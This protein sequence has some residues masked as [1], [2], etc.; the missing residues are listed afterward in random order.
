MVLTHLSKRIVFEAVLAMASVFVLWSAAS[1]DESASGRQR[2]RTIQPAQRLW[3]GNDP[4]CPQQPRPRLGVQ[5]KFIHLHDDGPVFETF[6]HGGGGGQHHGQEH[7]LRFHPQPNHH[8]YRHGVLIQRVLW[9][10]PAHRAGLER[11]DVIV[12]AQG[13]RISHAGSLPVAIQNSD[14]WL[15]L[16]IINVRNGRLADVWVHMG[17]GHDLQTAMNQTP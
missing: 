9:G 2:D 15:R 11:G 1:A 13:R 12:K 3:T 16:K 6:G 17:V 7:R 10:T 8:A 5:A 14:G 4:F